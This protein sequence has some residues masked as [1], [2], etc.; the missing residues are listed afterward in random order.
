[1]TIDI[2]CMTQQNFGFSGKF[3]LIQV[4]IKENYPNS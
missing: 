3:I 4:F 1:M 2:K